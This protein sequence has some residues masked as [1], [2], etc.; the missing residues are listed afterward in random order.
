MQ[1]HHLSHIPV[2]KGEM[3]ISAAEVMGS[4]SEDSLM[5][6]S[7]DTDD[8][9]DRFAEELMDPALPVVG[10]GESAAVAISKLESSPVLVVHDAGQPRS[11]LTRSHVMNSEIVKE[12]LEVESQ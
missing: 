4:L 8:I 3:P 12:Y 11:L 7:F 6:R 1:D 5:Q 2:A 10:L 9:L